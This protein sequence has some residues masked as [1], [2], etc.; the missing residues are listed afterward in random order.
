MSDLSVS[1]AIV[2]DLESAYDVAS[3]YGVVFLVAVFVF[4]MK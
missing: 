4:E 2:F 1:E 3:T